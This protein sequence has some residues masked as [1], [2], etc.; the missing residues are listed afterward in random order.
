MKDTGMRMALAITLG[1]TL[2]APD[3]AFAD[4][5]PLSSLTEM[6]KLD[7]QYQ[8]STGVQWCLDRLSFVFVAHGSNPTVDI[9]VEAGTITFEIVSDRRKAVCEPD[10]I[11]FFYEGIEEKFTKY[12]QLR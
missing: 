5:K 11:R 7:V 2:I 6:D 9:D 1:L 4:P 12:P 10:G 8:F 3:R